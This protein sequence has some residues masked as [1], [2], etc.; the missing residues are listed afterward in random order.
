M[1]NAVLIKCDY[2]WNLMDIYLTS[3]IEC[4]L[5][6]IDKK[7]FIKRGLCLAF[8]RTMILFDHLIPLYMNYIFSIGISFY[9]EFSKHFTFAILYSIWT[10]GE[11]TAILDFIV[12]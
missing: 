12:F 5:S 2:M 4:N 10:Y 11:I 3:D 9:I 8:K 1:L 6:F 7:K